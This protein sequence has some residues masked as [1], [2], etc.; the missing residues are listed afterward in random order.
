M[1]IYSFLFFVTHRNYYYTSYTEEEYMK[2]ATKGK[3][4]CLPHINGDKDGA[5][6]DT[7]NLKNGEV[8]DTTI[9]KVSTLKRKITTKRQLRT[10]VKKHIKRRS[11]LQLKPLV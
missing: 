1:L 5:A 8:G 10:S 2:G 3:Y 7:S 11:L 4:I 9:N 6:I